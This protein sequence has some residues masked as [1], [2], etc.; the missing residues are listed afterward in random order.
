M[1]L[2]DFVLKQR[3]YQMDLSVAQLS[4]LPESFFLYMCFRKHP[5]LSR[6]DLTKHFRNLRKVL[7]ATI[8]DKKKSSSGTVESKIVISELE[9]TLTHDLNLDCNEIEILLQKLDPISKAINC[10]LNFAFGELS[11][12]V[13]Y[14]VIGKSVIRAVEA[15]KR[16]KGY[17]EK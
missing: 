10:P 3:M 15:E 2:W 16:D 8:E 1:R 11:L 4:E 17:L 13:Q 9:T 7:K 5:Y 12:P 14:R 6:S